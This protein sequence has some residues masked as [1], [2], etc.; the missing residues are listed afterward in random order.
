[1]LALTRKHSEGIIL[2]LPDRQIVRIQVCSLWGKHVK[3]VK[4]GIEAPQSVEIVREELHVP[5]QNH[6]QMISR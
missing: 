5:Q 1:M 4:L 3:Q 2:V 6:R